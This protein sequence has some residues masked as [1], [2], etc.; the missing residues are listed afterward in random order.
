MGKKKLEKKSIK[1]WRCS[2]PECGVKDYIC[3]HLEKELASLVSNQSVHGH[4]VSYIETFRNTVSESKEEQSLEM[5]D[6]LKA[7]ALPEIYSMVLILRFVNNWSFSEIA[8]ELDIPSRQTAHAIY[9]R[10]LELLRERGYK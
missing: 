4:P 9:K 7:F 5:Y 6:K 8:D 2:V 3:Q 10:G 1:P